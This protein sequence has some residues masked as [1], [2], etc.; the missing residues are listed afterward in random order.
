MRSKIK[1]ITILMVVGKN[2]VIGEI[3]MSKEQNWICPHRVHSSILFLRETQ[4]DWCLP[5][6]PSM[7]LAHLSLKSHVHQSNWGHTTRDY[8]WDWGDF[9]GLRRSF[10]FF[11]AAQ[12]NTQRMEPNCTPPQIRYIDN[13]K[14]ERDAGLDGRRSRTFRHVDLPWLRKCH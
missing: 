13:V 9:F 6:P 14:G 10:D 3:R 1:G 2:N 8:N 4:H 5:H 12:G 11:T 7:M